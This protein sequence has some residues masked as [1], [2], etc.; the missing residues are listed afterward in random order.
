MYTLLVVGARTEDLASLAGAHAS[1]E[2]LRASGPDEAVEKLGR[3]RRV[4][5]VLLLGGGAQVAEAADAIREDNPAP[6]PL[7]A[8]SGPD[9]PPAGVR[10]IP[11]GTPAE[12]LASIVA[13][14][15]RE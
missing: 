14:I 4:D 15:G 7:F 1:V 5:A 13:G 2:I 9:G 12:W 11:A 8:V 10:S 6:P 3:N